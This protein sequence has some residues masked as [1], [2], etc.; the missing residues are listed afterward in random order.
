M[1]T[2]TSAHECFCVE[3]L[4]G[5]IYRVL[6]QSTATYRCRGPSSRTWTMGGRPVV[7]QEVDVRC[8]VVRKLTQAHNT[9]NDSSRCRRELRSVARS[10]CF[11]HCFATGWPAPWSSSR[12]DRLAL[13]CASPRLVQGA[14][15]HARSE[16]R[17]Q[18]S[19]VR[20]SGHRDVAHVTLIRRA[21]R[22]RTRA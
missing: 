1:Q 17:R 8:R 7:F 9:Q 15:V 21:P 2:R 6:E 3:V 14:A 5:L 18:P 12:L 20:G 19:R 11:F 13:P 22:S 10:A 16:Q 4:F